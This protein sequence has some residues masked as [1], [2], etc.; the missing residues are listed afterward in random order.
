MENRD[1]GKM[2]KNISSTNTTSNIGK[3][4]DSRVDFG[5]KIGRSENL[6]NEPGGRL[7]SQGSS[8]M[9]G[10]SGNSRAGS[11]SDVSSKSGSSKGS[12]DS[13]R[14]GDRE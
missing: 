7:G 8:G 1:H 13:G 4:S 11:S 5:E 6:N 14:G 3:K 12:R 2:N 9:K 10:S